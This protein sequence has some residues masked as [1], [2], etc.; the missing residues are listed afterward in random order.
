MRRCSYSVRELAETFCV[1]ESVLWGAIVSGE[2]RAQRFR[3]GGHE[4]VFVS[5]EAWEAWAESPR[6][7]VTPPVVVPT[8]ATS[9]ERTAR[10]AALAGCSL[11]ASWRAG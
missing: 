4:R 7:C 3:I 1:A 5:A 11:A 8:A 9:A 2:L 6:R 10:S